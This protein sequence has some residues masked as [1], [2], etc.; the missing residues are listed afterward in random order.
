MPRLSTGAA[1]DRARHR[2]RLVG[3]DPREAHRA[4]TPLELLFDLTLVVA[5]GTWRS[6]SSRSVAAAALGSG[7]AVSLVVLMFAPVVTVA[8]YETLGRRRLRAPG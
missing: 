1:P 3:R 6:C 2:R 4:A 5:F 8:G 7:L